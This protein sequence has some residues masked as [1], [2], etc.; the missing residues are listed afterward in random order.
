VLAGVAI[1]T[2]TLE[3]VEWLGE[4]AREALVE[5]WRV[6]LAMAPYLLVGFALAGIVRLVLKPER[7][8]PKLG[9][10]DLKSVAWA[11]LIGAPLPLCS[12]SVIPVALS[13]RKAGAS[14]GATSA[15]TVSTPETG[16]DSLAVTWA[17]LDPLLTVARPIGALVSAIASG[18]AV[19]W[20][21]RRG[22]DT[23]SRAVAP[24]A[25]AHDC[26]VHETPK[27]PPV[28]KSCCTEATP[29]ASAE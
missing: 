6:F 7:V 24:S 2:L 22:W 17:L 26:C 18:S 21:V 11:A 3:R 16:V 12:C 27:P 8:V 10:N 23:S 9:G 4:F 19:N 14:K 28:A 20:L 13:L 15:F 1:P 29:L 5:S 25:V